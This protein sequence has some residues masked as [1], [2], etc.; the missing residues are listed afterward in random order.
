MIIDQQLALGAFHPVFCEDFC[1]HYNLGDDWTVLAVMDGCSGG[2]DSHFAA[3]LL[4][5]IIYKISRQA[6]YWELQNPALKLTKEPIEI[7]GR[8]FIKAVFKEF[9]QVKQQLFLEP[10]ELASTCLLGLYHQKNKEVWINAS[11]DGVI[12]INEEV[13]LLDQEDKPN[14]M[15]YHHLLTVEEWL[16]EQTFSLYKKEV[17]YLALSTDGVLSFEETTTTIDSLQYL[18]GVPTQ[19]ENW[20]SL[21]KKCLILERDYQ[22]YP[23]DDLGIVCL[24]NP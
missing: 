11:G 7:L 16:E 14:Y 23:N 18:L 2:K 22:L 20:V 9:C 17:S 13:H 5:K 19:K 24:W 12:V 4:G 10:E 21:Q 8:H 3:A 1:V 6:P 15:T